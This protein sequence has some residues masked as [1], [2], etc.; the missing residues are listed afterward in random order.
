MG[1]APVSCATVAAFFDGED[2]TRHVG[3]GHV[4]GR[5]QV[6]TEQRCLPLARTLRVTLSIPVRTISDP[7]ISERP[8]R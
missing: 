6:R 5:W 1:A 4:E 8:P 7:Q 2:V 3:T